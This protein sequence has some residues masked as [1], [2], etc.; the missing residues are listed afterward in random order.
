ML[1]THLSDIALELAN[2]PLHILQNG[3]NSRK[4]GLDLPIMGRFT[5]VCIWLRIA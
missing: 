5:A 4:T 3:F 2:V 1:L